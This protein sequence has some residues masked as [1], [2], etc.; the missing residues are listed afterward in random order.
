[1]CVWFYCIL[2]HF[3]FTFCACALESRFASQASVTLVTEEP[4]HALFTRLSDVGTQFSRLALHLR[5][6]RLAS[7][8]P[9]ARARRT[10]LTGSEPRLR[11]DPPADR[12]S[13]A[14][15]WGVSTSLNSPGRRDAPQ[16]LL[17][18]LRRDS[19]SFGQCIQDLRLLLLTMATVAR[20]CGATHSAGLHGSVVDADVEF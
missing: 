1:M 14:I 12:P 18:S 13:L 10:C 17:S 3:F 19:S 15:R 11:V 9:T 5:T 20:S 6:P 2:T 7:S 16:Q 4:L 8:P